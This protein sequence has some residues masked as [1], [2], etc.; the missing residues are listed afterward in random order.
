MK[1]IKEYEIIKYKIGDY[2]L[3]NKKLINDDV[4]MR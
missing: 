3:L 2:V 4:L 1:Y